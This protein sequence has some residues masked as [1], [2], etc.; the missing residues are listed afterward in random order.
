M[1]GGL[2][3]DFCVILLSSHTLTTCVPPG[4]QIKIRNTP[5]LQLAPFKDIFT[6]GMQN[7]GI[8]PDIKLCWFSATQGCFFEYTRSIGKKNYL[9]EMKKIAL[10]L[11]YNIFATKKSF[12]GM[13]MKKKKLTRM[14]FVQPLVTASQHIFN[15]GLT[16]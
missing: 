7:S 12:L 16:C 11:I 9:F 4:T 1:Y 8:R 13:T 10:I 6:Q 15:S 2:L 5:F 14:F 3:I